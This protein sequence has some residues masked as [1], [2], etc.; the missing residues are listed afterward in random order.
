[1][2]HETYDLD[3]LA[4]LVRRR[5]SKLRV[6]NDGRGIDSVPGHHAFSNTYTIFSLWKPLTGVQ[7]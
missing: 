5:N 3:V 1:M 6:A 2:C 4:G 7:M